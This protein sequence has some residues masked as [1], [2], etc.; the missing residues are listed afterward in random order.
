MELTYHD[1]MKADLSALTTTATEWRSMGKGCDT[2]HDNYRDHVRKKLRGWLG[3]SAN[4]FWLSSNT[5]IHELDAAKKQAYK[6]ADLLDDAH[7]KLTEAR[8]HL[9]GVRDK[10]IDEGGM[11][12]DEYG[13]CTV[14][15]SKM[16]DKEARS[17]LHDPSRAD[18]EATWNRQI[19]TAVKQVDDAD[20]DV[21]VALKAAAKDTDGKGDPNGFNSKAVGDVE[22]YA[23]LRSAELSK[24]L[25]AKGGGLNP[26]E[27]HELQVLMRSNSDDRTFSRTLLNSLGPQGTIDMAN[28]LDAL[29]HGH[30]GGDRGQFQSIQGSLATSLATATKV[31]AFRG[32]GGKRLAVGSAEYGKKY[33]AWLD[34]KD[35]AFY[36]AWRKG[37][38]KAGVREW[39]YSVLPA[40]TAPTSETKGRGYQSLITLME[41][42]DGYAPQMLHDLGDDIRAAEEKDRDIWDDKGR[43]PDN[44][45]TGRR[46]WFA[47][48]PY[49]GL[50]GIMSKDPDTSAAY[51]DPKADM[52]PSTSAHEKND[53]LRYLVEDR[54]WKIVDGHVRAPD[55]VDQDAH[56]GFQKALEAGTTGRLPGT[57]S[58]RVSPEH[59]EANART[60]AEAVDVFGSKPSIL[61]KGGDFSDMRSALGDMIADYPGDVQYGV[62]GDDEYKTHGVKAEFDEARL[63]AYLGAVG[64]DP[65]AY[66]VIKSSQNL[67]T[68]EHLQDVV[69]D[70]PPGVSVPHARI[71]AG[72]AIAGGAYVQGILSEAKADALYEDKIGE[73]SDFNEKAE[74]KSKWI[75]RFVGLGTGSVG[76]GE[77]VSTPVGAVQEE[78]N[79]DVMDQINKDIPRIAQ[80][81]EDAGKYDFLTMRAA[82][83]KF[84]MD[85]AGNATE[86]A[87]LESGIP[88]A[89][90]DGVRAK[91]NSLF[92]DG[93]NSE[94]SKGSVDP[95]G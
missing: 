31:P 24:R 80:E 45:L 72:D 63:H 6:I 59:S 55:T 71:L 57:D 95:E 65:H 49:D 52:D 64:T 78:L 88:S 82:L 47:N 17:A 91:V 36:G 5:T 50:L 60:M 76:G 29:T 51:F 58:A 83:R 30:G 4:A 77:L 3:E 46:R 53:R 13:K 22:K 11:K 10:A 84:Y 26:A 20:Y 25:N 44:S 32:A 40:G 1:V 85:W 54:D 2:V 68:V 79:E 18:A 21:M 62:T 35:G 8:D 42:G 27:R 61:R 92:D 90:K 43:F 15:T 28:K 48:D 67:Y 37:M 81:A 23:A 56:E 94:R 93:G 75:N 34:S 14:D 19:R 38:Q 73:A 89:V 66:G 70:L 69:N 7:H 12:V 41:H 74:E 9:K 39:S 16:T 87:D 33:R 86:N